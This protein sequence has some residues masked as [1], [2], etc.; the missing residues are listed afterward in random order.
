MRD[1]VDPLGGAAHAVTVDEA[2][3]TGE[4][5]IVS[6]P[7]SAYP[8]LPAALLADKIVVDTGNYYPARDGHVAVLDAGA[9]TSSEILAAE[10]PGAQVVKMFN[11]ISFAHLRDQ[12]E[13]PDSPGRRALPMAGDDPAAKATVAQLVDEIGFDTV[14]AGALSTGRRFEPGSPAYNVRLDAGELAAAVAD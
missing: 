4:L 10:L 2:A 1:L 9:T 6:V 5:V 13:A 3:R 12:P 8:L 7:V 14:D 11:T